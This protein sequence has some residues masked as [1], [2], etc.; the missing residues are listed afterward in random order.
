MSKDY[1]EILS[2]PRSASQEEIKRAYRKLALK[3][4]PDRNQGNKESEKKFKEASEAYQILGDSKKRAHYDRFGHTK[5]GTGNGF[6]FQNV[7]DIF[8]SFKDIFE[9]PDFFKDS[10]GGGLDSF[11]SH[12]YSQNIQRRGSDLRYHLDLNLKEVL[13][14]AKKEV[15]FHGDVKCPSCK[16][17]GSKP[18]TGYKKCSHCQG[19]GQVFSR[20]GFISFA[21]T[22]PQCH[23][24]G[25]VLES[26]CAECH[27]LGKRKKKRVLTIKIPAG[28]DQGA[29]LRMRGEGDPG[30]LGGENGDLYVEIHIQKDARFKK[31]GKDIKTACSISY[32]QALLGTEIRV[33]GLEGQETVKILAGTQSGDEVCI[34]R[35]GLPEVGSSKRGNL[36]CEIQVKIPKK[37]K[38]KEEELL[39]EIAKLKKES[40]SFK[41][42]K[43]LF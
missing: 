29:R 30:T 38:K 5:K 33:E 25:S 3:Y 41:K 32:L 39:Q 27:G 26:P 11:F 14:G 22:C 18:K 34:S 36:I 1:Y 10:F 35:K 2:I 9:H 23:G 12:Q 19:R 42:K 43:G 37:L 40:V 20:N 8:S 7:H 15:S 16:G 21:S 13:K 17:S 4:H 6:G 28:V 24:K 31:E